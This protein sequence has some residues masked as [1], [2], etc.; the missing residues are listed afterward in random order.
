MPK[1]PGIKKLKPGTYKI[2]ATVVC[3][4]TNTRKDIRKVVHCRSAREAERE[5]FQLIQD[6]EM[7]KLRAPRVRVSEYCVSWLEGRKHRLKTSTRSR[8]AYNLKYIAEGLGDIYMDALT[9]GDVM[10][11]MAN[12]AEK[13]SGSS[14]QGVLRVLRTMTRDAVVELDLARWPC[15]RVKNPKPP[16]QYSEEDPNLLNL[17]ELG[18]FLHAAQEV[19]NEWYPLI[20]FLVFTGC[21][22]GEA[23]A[24][25]WEDIDNQKKVIRV[26]RNHYRGVL[27]ETTKTGTS[28]TL[29]L[30][31]GLKEV[32]SMQRE[33]LVVTHPEGWESGWVFPNKT[34]RLQ[35]VGALGKAMKRILAK[36]T[37]KHRV[38]PH[39]LR[40]TLNNT[41]RQVAEGEVLR[42]ITGHVTEAM[43]EHY[44]HVSLG[45]KHG[46]VKRMEALVEA[47]R[48]KEDQKRQQAQDP[49]TGDSSAPRVEG[50]VSGLIWAG[51][52][53]QPRSTN[54]AAA[55]PAPATAPAEET[56]RHT[57]VASDMPRGTL[58]A[59]KGGSE[60]DVAHLVAH[61]SPRTLYALP[62]VTPEGA[63]KAEVSS[64]SAG[65]PTET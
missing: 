62:S 14:C 64:T 13:Y 18:E 36:T 44:S 11:F 2:R 54:R 60:M 20:Y 22:F 41:L 8:H 50:L 55:K 21:R 1:T 53:D 51:F 3:P 32:L 28:R 24:L 19:E 16:K 47:T 59:V 34:G 30:S 9:P 48:L 43:S 61:R 46:A 7:G 63:K 40:R 10:K 12:M 37:I 45:E 42:S 35:D 39:G 6:A 23:T 25:R 26:R 52:T 49:A 17:D 15:E 31:K 33:L 4:K 57:A 65:D 27:Q 38:T 5:L 56:P 58:V 29:P